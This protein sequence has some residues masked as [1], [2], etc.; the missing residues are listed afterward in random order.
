[1]WNMKSILLFVASLV[2]V[3][4]ISMSMANADE[5]KTITLD[6][7]TT[8]VKELPT[9]VSSWSKSE[10]EK[11]KEFQKKGWAEAKNQWPWNKIFKG[12]DNE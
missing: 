9:K 10:W 7:V 2:V 1:M 4:F 8:T 3:I 6:Q 12:K 5:K 11:T